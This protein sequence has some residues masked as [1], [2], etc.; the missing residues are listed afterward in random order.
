M[1]KIN[2]CVCTYKRDKLLSTC[3][4]SLYNVD[5][6]AG[7]KVTLTVIDN[8]SERCA[9]TVI[10]RLSPI[11]T[12]PT[13]YVNE[14][15]R[16]IPHARNRAIKE[17]L[18]LQA[19]YLIFLDDDE[20]A[21]KDWLKNLYQYCINKGGN[22]VVS[23]RVI[24]KLPDNVSEDIAPLLCNKRHRPTGTSLTACATNNVIFPLAL[25]QQLA[26]KFDAS[27]PQAGGEDT[28]FF[29]KM[30]NEG[31]T[32]ECCAEAILYE[33]ISSDRA[34]LKWLIQR[35]F[36]AG[37]IN[38]WRKMQQGRWW[39]SIIISSSIQVLFYGLLSLLLFVAGFS[40]Q[41]NRSLLKMSRSAGEICGLF[42]YRVNS[43]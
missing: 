36:W 19:K 16:G 11:A 17:S 13:Y 37:T 20:H 35:K 27:N 3:L 28:I 34:T 42:G 8:H 41:R 21:P 29:S 12:I 38:A 5:I 32:I 31:V 26:L 39:P 4:K 6:P 2:I 7:S 40:L 25:T 22:L 1:D 43:Y 14:P 18:S 23:G 24:S 9:K 33:E 15:N 10:D 30:A